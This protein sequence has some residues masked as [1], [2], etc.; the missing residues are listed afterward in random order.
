MIENPAPPNRQHPLENH[1]RTDSHLTRCILLLEFL[2][3]L[4]KASGTFLN[5]DEAMHVLAA[6]KPSLAEAYRASLGLAHPPLLIL[7]LNLW[8]KLGTSEL[9]LRLPAVI[10]GTIFCW[11]FFKWLTRCSGPVAAWAGLVLVSFLPPFVEL[12]SEVRQY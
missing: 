4:W 6:T 7:L 12:S 3:R 1:F 5:L 11:L 9:G 2:L 8:R 10:A